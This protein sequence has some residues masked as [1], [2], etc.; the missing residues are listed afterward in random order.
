M[1]GTRGTV[2][3][4]GPPMGRDFLREVMDMPR[5]ACA[6]IFSTLF[7][8]GSSD[9]ASGSQYC[10]NLFLLNNISTLYVADRSVRNYRFI[11]FYF[12][13]TTV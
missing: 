7:A 5:L 13:L 4:P 8:R 9:A 11:S 2:Q 10:S 1:E 6:L 12:R 3:G